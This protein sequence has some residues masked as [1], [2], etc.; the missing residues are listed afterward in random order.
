MN[1]IKQIQPQCFLADLLSDI[2]EMEM[3]RTEN[4]MLLT[5]KILKALKQKEFPKMMGK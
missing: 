2:D 5:M 1:N 4:R 3:K